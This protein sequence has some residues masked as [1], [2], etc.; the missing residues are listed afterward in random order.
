MN[1]WKEEE[2]FIVGKTYPVP[3]PKYLDTVCT[4]GI[5]RDEKWIRLYPVS[6]R[7]LEMRKQ[8]KMYS[9]IKAKV[10]KNMRD[11]R[12]ETHIVDEKSLSV[13]R[14]VKSW[15]ERRKIILPLKVD[16]LE[17]LIEQNSKD[18][19]SVSMGIFEI[20]YIDF[21]W[22]KTPR[23]WNAR[24]KTYMS[25]MGLS[26]EPHRQPVDKLPYNFK[27]HYKCKDNP[28]CKGHKQSLLL[29]EY[30]QAFR[31]FTEIYG[32]EE[33]ALKKMKEAFKEKIVNPKN[34][35][36]VLTGT[37]H[38]HPTTWVVGNVF[39]PPKKEYHQR[40]LIG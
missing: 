21:Y 29:W 3:S 22:E 4:G 1:N 27:L 16:C 35:H 18:W 7:Y 11:H 32:S 31:N 23:E 28:K 10:K 8:Y 34:E 40:H 13:I 6:Y 26:F 38:K 20:E 5:T 19:K 14:E 33:N 37:L 25:Q 2:I 12:S 24:Q 15:D 39:C 30:G 17:H 36:Y 9:W